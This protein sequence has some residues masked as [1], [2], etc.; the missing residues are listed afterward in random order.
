MYMNKIKVLTVAYIAY[1]GE[2]FAYFYILN[3]GE[4]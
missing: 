3:T 1:K 4:S 2:M